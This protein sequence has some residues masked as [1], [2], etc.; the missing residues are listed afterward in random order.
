MNWIS[1]K[2][3]L[4]AIGGQYIVSKDG[5]VFSAEFVPAAGGIKSF[6][7]GTFTNNIEKVTHWMPLPEPPEEED[8]E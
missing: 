3:S 5:F 6:W 7:C 1:V 2:D 4:P 8:N